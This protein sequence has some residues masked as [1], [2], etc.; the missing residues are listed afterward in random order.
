VLSLKI[1]PLYIKNKVY[2]LCNVL[3]FTAFRDCKKE[4]QRQTTNFYNN[5]QQRETVKFKDRQLIIFAGAG[6]GKTK[7]IT[8]RMAYLNSQGATDLYPKLQERL[9]QTPKNNANTKIAQ[10]HKY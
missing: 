7:V 4:R 9:S 10:H 2:K 5:K 1:F 8:H 6:T 3:F